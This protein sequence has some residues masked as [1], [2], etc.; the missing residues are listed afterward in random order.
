[1][2]GDRF[3]SGLGVD[4]NLRLAHRNYLL[5]AEGKKKQKNKNKYKNF[6]H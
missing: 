4:R 6:F 3:F 1:M 2:L 5:A